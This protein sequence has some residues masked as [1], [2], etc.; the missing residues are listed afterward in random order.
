VEQLNIGE[1]ARLAEMSQSAIRYYESVGLLP[2]PARA[3]GWRRYQPEIVDRLRVIRAARDIGFTLEEIHTL[4][5]GFSSDVAPPARWQELA[6]QKLPE[7]DAMV[8]R[9]QA[10]RKLLQTG[11]TCTCVRIEDCF[12]DDC[13]GGVAAVRKPAK[14]RALP[15][16]QRA[17]SV[18][19]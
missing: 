5:D 10:L 9:A 6:R 19:Q 7:I 12:L 13:S 3:S 15:I 4:L 16:V 2:V 11:L 18:P 8:R 14:S 17:V 1:V